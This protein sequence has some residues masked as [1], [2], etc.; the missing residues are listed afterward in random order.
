MLAGVS[1]IVILAYELVGMAFSVYVG[2]LFWV[3]AS[4]LVRSSVV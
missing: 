3:Y 2:W 1:A 4:F